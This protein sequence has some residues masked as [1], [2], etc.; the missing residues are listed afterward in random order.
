MDQAMSGDLF[1]S[2]LLD[3]WETLASF[4]RLVAALR[5][6]YDETS[7][8]D[9]AV[10]AHR[11]KG[12]TA[13][14][15]YPQMSRLAELAER[16]LELRP[17]LDE[18][19]RE[20]LI[21]FLERL[22]VCLR[23]AL[24]R[25]SAQEGEGELGLTFA[26]LGGT[27]LL[28]Q[29]LSSAPKAFV[30]K[31]V[32][33]A[34]GRQQNLSE[35]LTSFARKNAE[36]WTYFAPEAREH[37][38]LMRSILDQGARRGED[39][40]G[41]FRSAHTLKGSS[42]M[43]GCTPLGDLG[44]LLEDVL[45]AA[46]EGR[47]DLQGGAALVLAEG[48]D[49]AER[50]LLVAE[51]EETDLTRVHRHT[52]RKLLALRGEEDDSANI[53]P[54]AT[55]TPE[56]APAP[57]AARGADASSTVR[58]S[59][60]K[61]DD[62][63]RSVGELIVRRSRLDYQLEQFADLE[64]LL[65][66]ST[67]RLSRTVLEFEEKYL[68]PH[69]QAAGSPETTDATA[70]PT[71]EALRPASSV[72]AT[73][74]ELFDELEFDSYGDLNVVARAV[75]EMSAD[76]AELQQSFTTRLS[77]LREESESLGKLARSVRT[78]V[79]RARRVPFSGAAARLK[80]WART[81]GADILKLDVQGE[82]VEVD[83]VVLEALTAPLLH[84]ANN[85]LAHGVEPAAVREAL[86]KPREGQLLVRAE[87]RG[88]F[89]DVEFSDD[90][91]G[92][93]LA[94]VREKA[95][96]RVND[97]QLNAMSDDELTSLIFLPGLSTSSE[98]TSEAG[99]GVGMDVVSEAVRRLGGQVLVRSVRGVG[100]TFTLRVPLTQQITDA[101]VFTVGDLLGGF[102]TG[103]VRALN[104]VPVGSVLV[105]DAGE[106]IDLAGERLRLY[107]LADLLGYTPPQEEALKVIVVESGGRKSAV[108][109]DGFVGL[110]ELA[111][112]QPGAL[113]GDVGYLAGGALD[114]A[115]NVVLLFDPLGVE[116]LS[117]GAVSTG[118][119]KVS[120]RASAKRVLLVDD[121]VSV[122]RVVSSMLSRAGYAVKT[123]GDGAEALDLL[124]VDSD[125][126]AVL[127]DLEMPRV[128]GFELIEEVR[129]RPT[130]AHLPIVVMTTRAGD[131]HQ[132]LAKS[133]GA[134]DYFSKPIDEA[135]LLR[136]LADLTSAGI[137]A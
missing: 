131:K 59:T 42:Y 18:E 50:M 65:A 90:G 19:G 17:R 118:L 8:H 53:V 24:E 23:G 135:R 75:S 88:A 84:L 33:G 9:L 105:T 45:G 62:L 125:F 16:L 107:R 92:I 29:L 22:A 122:R 1:E 61:L 54:E 13:L 51:G 101:L 100:T 113:L 119:P 15:G 38:E 123:A 67:E 76:L 66:A 11:I 106:Q 136:R 95:R 77:V 109:V 48:I 98:V 71:A 112:R 3:S 47:L 57:S 44:H 39:L 64:R 26:E 72:T 89:L 2:F 114:R 46:R 80:R 116:Q 20:G 32:D 127:T 81:R 86:G 124:R 56:P 5:E 14:Y 68:H 82:N 78:D 31:T 40:T 30:R 132:T 121:S 111:V 35:Q 70:E 102:P 137:R 85:A 21:A 4:E 108:V 117:G 120:V 134:T 73:V 128:N 110:E 126:S 27:A 58:V 74:S 69:L 115:G 41:L 96:G 133:L 79:S 91:A 28:Q 99:R 34:D 55:A 94:T 6:R 104:E 60:R 130:T 10:I 25:V 12:T 93:D 49:L 36:I 103:M 129:R 52:R 83:T 37:I 63:M 43:V 87:A 7:L 97:A